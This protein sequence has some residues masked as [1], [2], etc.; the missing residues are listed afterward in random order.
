ML[1]ARLNEVVKS[2]DTPILFQYHVFKTTE[3]LLIIVFERKKIFQRNVLSAPLQIYPILCVKDF[4]LLG[5]RGTEYFF[6]ILILHQIVKVC[7]H[8][9]TKTKPTSLQLGIFLSN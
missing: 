4:F 2:I 9:N 1:D 3:Y 6:Y 8:D 7:Y 5:R